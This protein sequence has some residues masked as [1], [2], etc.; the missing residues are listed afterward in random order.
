MYKTKE[1]IAK[2]VEQSTILIHPDNGLWDTKENWI[3]F[4]EDY[5]SMGGLSIADQID[6]L[7]AYDEE[8]HILIGDGTVILL[9]DAVEITSNF[10]LEEDNDIEDFLL[11]SKFELIDHYMT[12]KQFLYVFDKCNLKLKDI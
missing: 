4:S 11:T 1:Q 5:S 2:Q 8:Q 3:N 7:I 6:L 12:F 9:D 10:L